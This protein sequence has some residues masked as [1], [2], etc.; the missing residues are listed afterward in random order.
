MSCK[1]YYFKNND[2]YCLKKEDYVDTD[3]YYQYCRNYDYDD[4]PIYKAESTGCFITSACIESYG[5]DDNCEELF[6]LRNFRDTY[7]KE[8]AKR[9]IEIKEYY[10]NAPCIVSNINKKSNRVAIYKKIY[11]ELISPCVQYI[12]NND[13]EKAYMLYKEY[14]YHLKGLYLNT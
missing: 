4:C 7:M 14:Y 1:F 2:Y 12:K 5:L 8:N 9:I 6:I 13:Y 11:N 10:N 3:T